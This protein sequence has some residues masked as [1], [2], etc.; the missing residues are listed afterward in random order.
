MARSI[1][2]AALPLLVLAGA[3]V[4]NNAD[5]GLVI[6]RN[7]APDLKKNVPQFMSQA[8]PLAIPRHTTPD[9]SGHCHRLILLVKRHEGEP[10]KRLRCLDFDHM[11]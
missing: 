3:C 2:S 4:D 6:L 5:S 7:I 10:V 8:Q 11:D 9:R 1:V